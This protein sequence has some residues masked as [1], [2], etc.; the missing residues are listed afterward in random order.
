MALRGDRENT[1]AQ[2][3]ALREARERFS[4]AL[5][6]VITACRADAGVA[7]VA[8]ESRLLVRSLRSAAKRPPP[9]D[10]T[11]WAGAVSAA[12]RAA[13]RSDEWDEA[14]ARAR[15]AET[16]MDLAALDLYSAQGGDV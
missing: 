2:T 15:A 8:Q 11:A 7:E 6:G 10:T 13:A 12:T 1:S 14:V 5:D 9:V 16:A 4:D 3:A